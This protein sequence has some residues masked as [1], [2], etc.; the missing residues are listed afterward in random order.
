MNWTL[1]VLIK[2][3]LNNLKYQWKGMEKTTTV[4]SRT[5]SELKV[6]WLGHGKFTWI[7]F[8]CIVKKACESVQI[9]WWVYFS[10]E[11]RIFFSFG[12]ILVGIWFVELQLCWN[13]RKFYFIFYVRESSDSPNRFGLQRQ[14]FFVGNIF[15]EL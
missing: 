14:V 5:L 7:L 6:Q 12:E 11:K 9:L 13:W 2:R 1:N 8:L 10:D 15:I 4:K 3:H